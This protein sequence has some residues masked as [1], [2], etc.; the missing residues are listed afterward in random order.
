M[1]TILKTLLISLLLINL[2][3]CNS[4]RK[5][6][7]ATKSK[8]I[9]IPF[10]DKKYKTDK[11]HFRAVQSGTS[12]EMATAKK[13]ATVN[14]KAE[15]ASNIQSTIKIVTENYTNQRNYGNKIEI[16]NKFEELTK[17]VTNQLLTNVKIIDEKLLKDK[18]GKFTY[19]IAVEMNK[20][21]VLNNMQNQISKDEKLQIDF[22]KFQ[23]EK[24]FNQEMEKYNN[25]QN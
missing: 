10:S 19:W 21:E 25:F 17:E 13:I 22:D 18:S 9:E 11:N 4:E 1:K 15:L 24:I 7:K 2:I 6:T 14:A 8:E 16:E 23:F 20:D 5:L 3:G 12:T